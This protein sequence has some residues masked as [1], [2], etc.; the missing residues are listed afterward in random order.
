MVPVPAS[1]V[2]LAGDPSL[3]LE[4]STL[5]QY[6]GLNCDSCCVGCQ[7]VRRRLHGRIAFCDSSCRYVMLAVF[8]SVS[9]WQILFSLGPPIIGGVGTAL[10]PRRP[11]RKGEQRPDSGWGNVTGLDD[12]FASL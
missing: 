7:M 8:L 3:L 6:L 2:Q 10:A 5:S 1:L 9:Q 12:R 4:T 11:G